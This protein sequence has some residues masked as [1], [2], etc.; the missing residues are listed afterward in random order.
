MKRIAPI[1]LPGEGIPPRLLQKLYETFR[2]VALAINQIIDAMETPGDAPS[3]VTLGA[4][5]DIQTASVDGAYLVSGGTVTAIEYRRGGA[6]YATGVVAG[7]FVVAS[8]DSIRITYTVAPTVYFV[9]Q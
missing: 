6:N 8:G 5:P 2:A 7:Q 9:A 4:S 3:T 1:S